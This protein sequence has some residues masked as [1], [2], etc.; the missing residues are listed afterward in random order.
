MC[1][2]RRD[3]L[4]GAERAA[5]AGERQPHL[6]LRQR[7]AR[8]DLAAVLV[9]PLRGD[10]Q[11][12]AAAAVIGNRQR[13]LETEERLVLH[14]DLVR[15]L[16]DDRPRRRSRSPATIALMADDVAVGMDRR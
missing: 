3:V 1:T 16:D 4:A 12:D 10:V 9:Q 2:C 13:R 8:G 7:Q 11:L 6:V 14:P 5:D 15:A